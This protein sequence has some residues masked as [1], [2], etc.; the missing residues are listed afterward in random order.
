MKN[1]INNNL[2][3][4]L[5]VPDFDKV[6]K[7]YSHLG[8]ETVFEHIPAEQPGY[9]VLKRKSDLGNTLLNFYGGDERVYNQSFFKQFPKDTQR[10]YATE[11]TIPVSDI[12][13]EYEKVK[14]VIPNAVV[15]ELK[16]LTDS[17]IQW[18]DFRIIDPF[19]YYIRI[20]ELIAWG[21]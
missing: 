15:R 13:S 5:H 9:L 7:F 19:G 20:T 21:Q 16:E 11:I 18:K 6:K 1:K 14:T 17:D 12:D 8:F 4:E 3:I 2:I 10:G